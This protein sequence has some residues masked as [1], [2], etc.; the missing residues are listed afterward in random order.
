MWLDN[1]DVQEN[2]VISPDSCS[3]FDSDPSSPWE[4]A[5][6]A[7]QQAKDASSGSLNPPPDYKATST[8]LLRKL[9]ELPNPRMDTKIVS[10]L[11]LDGMYPVPCLVSVRIAYT[12]NLCVIGVIDIFMSHMT[13]FEEGDSDAKPTSDE[14]GRLSLVEK[15]QLASR[16]RKWDD[17][18]AI[19][20]SYHAMELLCGT[21]SNHY[22]VQ[23][24]CLDV[25]GKPKMKARRPVL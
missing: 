6:R 10:V 17:A 5:D 16:S 19:E 18:K 13:C 25:I 9:L 14:L 11:L 20:R 7:I 1:N 3:S 2:L 12:K 23:D 15:V 21:S 4:T 24:V 8:L 22:R